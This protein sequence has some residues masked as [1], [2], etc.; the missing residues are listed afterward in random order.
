MIAYVYIM[1]YTVTLYEPLQE[2]C[3]DIKAV[4][5]NIFLTYFSKF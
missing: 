2:A 4:K 1:F 5:L 3:E